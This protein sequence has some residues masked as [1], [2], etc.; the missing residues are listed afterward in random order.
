MSSLQDCD[1][2]GNCCG[3]K[4]LFLPEVPVG[5]ERVRDVAFPASRKTKEK[6]EKDNAET[7]RHGR[8]RRRALRSAV[9]RR[10]I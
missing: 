1:S 5:A 9:K 6:H 2:P 3:A 4:Q 8:G 10:N 7:P